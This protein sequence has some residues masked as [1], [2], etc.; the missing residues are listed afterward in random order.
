VS[1]PLLYVAYP[2][3]LDL[4]AA[5]AIQTYNTVRELRK[6]MPGM[7]LVVPRWLLEKSAF[8]DLGALHLPRP[9]VNKLSRFV[10]WAGW[11]YIERTLYSLMLV[12]LLMVWRVTGRGYRVLYVRDAVCAAWL[13]VFGWAHGAK[14]IYEVHDLEAAHPSKASKWPRRFWSRFLPWLDGVALRKA[15]KLVSLT[16]TFREWVGEGGI[17]SKRDVAVIP[18]AF[19]PALCYPG[20]AL[21]AR[22][23]LGLPLDAHITGYAG[24]TFAYRRLDLLV[25]AF[26][27]AAS[28]DPDG[29]LVLVGGRPDEVKEL[30]ELAEKL[31][32]PAERLVM[33]GQIGQAQTATYLRVADVLVIPDTVTGMTASPLKLFEYMAVGK[34]IV[35]KDMPALREIVDESCAIFFPEGDA[36]AFA[37]ALR[38]LMS[39]PVGAKRLGE[40][41][42][43]RSAGY[44]YQARAQRVAEVVKSCR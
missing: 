44:T 41:A 3:R 19:D 31:D 13:C 33:P 38:A 10:P 1:R 32:I 27:E 5:N 20:D 36:D 26:A 15:C 42:L 40:E 21:E 11:S 17:R 2:M 9:A 29:V 24:L 6:I 4:G 22:R 28:D 34:P 16:Q 12:V 18:D 7:R 8:S 30:R 23:D 14:I 39:D 37:G 35:C 25:E 43:R